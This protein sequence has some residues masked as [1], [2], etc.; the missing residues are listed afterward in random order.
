MSFREDVKQRLAEII[1]Y[2]VFL[3]IGFVMGRV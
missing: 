2:V 3:I 1:P